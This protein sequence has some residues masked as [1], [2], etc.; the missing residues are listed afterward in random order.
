[1]GGDASALDG[2]CFLL[3]A[4]DGRAASPSHRSPTPLCRAW[5]LCPPGHPL[6]RLLCGP[7]PPLRQRSPAPLWP[8]VARLPTAR[9][10]LPTPPRRHPPL[11]PI[12]RQRAPSLGGY[13][14]P[15][16][17]PTY[18]ALCGRAWPLR[19]PV[20]NVPRLLR[21]AILP[22]RPP[23][24]TAR[25]S[26]RTAL[27]PLR[28]RSPAPLWPGVVSL[29]TARQRPRLLPGRPSPSPTYPGPSVARRG[30]IP[31]YGWSLRSGSNGRL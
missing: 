25:G 17:S 14:P 19:L 18:P 5:P 21:R 15:S 28:Q 13:D 6:P 27:H 30:L 8:G 9:Q 26:L 10:R 20:A 1:M 16:P 11:S 22:L 12:H 24:A 3:W 29:P 2:A 31:R 7:A 4:V 23:V